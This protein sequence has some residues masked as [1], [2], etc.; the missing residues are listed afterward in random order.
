MTAW[1]LG[2]LRDR[3]AEVV[4]EVERTHHRVTSTRHGHAVAVLISPD[5]LDALEETIDRATSCKP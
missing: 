2:D 1:P 4:S 3:L 5:G